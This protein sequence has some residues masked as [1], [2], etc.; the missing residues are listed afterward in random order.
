MDGPDT[1]Q[2]SRRQ[3]EALAKARLRTGER[4][5]R[6]ESEFVNDG[7]TPQI[8]REVVEEAIR[9]A[10][11][12]ATALLIGSTSFAGLGLLVTLAS[13]LAATSRPYGGTY[14]IWFGP[15]VGGGI[16]ALIA[17]ARLMSI[18]P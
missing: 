9:N 14:L 13:Y 15:V 18:R 17:L 5:S 10:R 12:S 2:R 7:L 11:A 3:W 1:L 4:A 6:I 8:A 16:A